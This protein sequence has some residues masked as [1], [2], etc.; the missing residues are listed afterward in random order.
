MAISISRYVS[1]NSA[2]LGQTIV[3]VR[4]LIMN[5]FTVNP[6]LPPQTYAVFS[7]A[8]EVGSYF[9]T[10]SEEYYR[11]SQYF[12]WTSK[13]NTSPTSIQ[14]TRWVK[15]GVAGYIYGYGADVTLVDWQSITDGSIGLTI[16]A[17]TAQLSGLDFSAVHSL[18][19]AAFALTGTTTSSSATITMSDTTGIVVGMSVTGTGI[20]AATI[21][22]SITPNTSIVV[23]NM[24]TASGTVSLTFGQNWSVLAVL[25][26]AINGHSAGGADWTAATMS[27][28]NNNFNLVG[29][30]VG[31]EAIAVQKGVTGHDISG[32]V[33]TNA[34]IG[35]Y[36]Q[37]S[38]SNGVFTPGAIWG[39]GSVAE[40]ITTTLTN[41][42][43]ANNNFGTIVF[44]F[45]GIPGSIVLTGTLSSSSVTVT[46]ISSTAALAVGMAVSGTDIPAGTTIASIVSS[47][48]ITLSQAA[49]GS[50][51]TALTFTDVNT[52]LTLAQYQEAANWNYALKPNNQ[53]KLMV[54]VTASNY[55]TWTAAYPTGLG[56]IGG[57]CTTLTNYAAPVSAIT[58]FY[59]EA[60]AIIEA[61]TNYNPG[62]INSVQNYEFQLF[63]A[64]PALV[65]SD[66]LANA[67]DARR[68]NYIGV[69][70]NAG[71]QIAF[72]QQ[73]FLQGGASDATD[74]GVY[75]NEQWLKSAITAAIMN[76]LLS[77]SYVPAN[78]QGNAQI[79]ASLQSV[80]QQALTNG[81]ISVGKT[82][83]PNQIQSITNITGN[84]L[85]WQQVQ[86]AGYYLVV[87]IQPKPN[88][89]PVVYEA[90]YTLVYSKNDVIRFVQGND[91]LI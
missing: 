39:Q 72:Y 25:L 87:T 29:G 35:W 53:F 52:G 66:A 83:T 41:A 89:S 73:G 76:L 22:N 33:T 24:A 69:T 14:F 20:P 80:I 51:T 63:P 37:A 19:A 5:V 47:T 50:T 2:V 42:Y 65:N 8:A 43:N 40:S 84:N 10:T 56:G 49:T 23:S 9:G 64:F 71:Q 60:D 1:I 46:S 3:G 79:T 45:T 31:N 77:Q 54:P 81:T 74:S 17:T 91:D 4:Q 44:N 78:A 26:T 12:N 59:E 15:G 28:S 85:A 90:V 62:A 13:N 36:N 18:S 34:Q 21:V 86:N 27:Y 70:Q 16:G 57:V 58:I 55:S 6:L 7:S 88:T 68:V 67:Y 75:A 38:T 48:S 61:A 32:F 82:L 30:V 11:A